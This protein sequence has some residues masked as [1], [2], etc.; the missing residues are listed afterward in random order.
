MSLFKEQK[1][2]FLISKL[3]KTSMKIVEVWIVG[4]RW[5]AASTGKSGRS[6]KRNGW[7]SVDRLFERLW[8]RRKTD[9]RCCWTWRMWKRWRQ[10]RA[11]I[12]MWI[13]N[14]RLKR[15]ANLFYKSFSLG[16][17]FATISYWHWFQMGISKRSNFSSTERLTN[18]WTKCL[19][20]R[21]EHICLQS[22][23]Q[24]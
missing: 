15:K 13:I 20:S 23:E 14:T 1:I 3:I 18:R 10:G 5:S 8:R 12:Q 2:L 11:M 19:T 7:K 16:S 24:L 21:N 9:F 4:R 22:V 17:F 6:S